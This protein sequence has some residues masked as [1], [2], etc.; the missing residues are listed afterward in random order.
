[1][2]TAA[3]HILLRAVLVASV[4]FG[5]NATLAQE[6]ILSFDSE[7][8]IAADGSLD[9]TETIAIRAEGNNIRRGI[10]RDFP[11]RYT[12]RNG[13]RFVVDFSVVSLQRDGAPEPFFTERV[14]NGVQVNFGNDDF[15]P[16][17][18]EFVY[19]LRYRTA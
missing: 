18:G 11:T 16:V 13:L 14:K 12:D 1:M 3:V 6:R 9:V 19:T 7:V 5:G 4:L 15:L 8:R 17:P 10:Y 2:N